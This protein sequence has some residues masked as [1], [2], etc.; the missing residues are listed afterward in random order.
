MTLTITKA[1]TV[2]V[3]VVAGAGA[4]LVAQGAMKAG[5]ERVPPYREPSPYMSAADIQAAICRE[6]HGGPPTAQE[7]QP[8]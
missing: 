3:S 6:R 4:V 1:L 7:E 8:R 5:H 2:V